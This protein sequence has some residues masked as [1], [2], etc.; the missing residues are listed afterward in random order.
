MRV[1]VSADL[2]ER[3]VREAASRRT[4]VSECVRADLREFHAIKDELMAPLEVREDGGEVRRRIIH[5]LVAEMETRVVAGLDR[6]SVEF[7]S[8]VGRQSVL[9]GSTINQAY[10]GIVV[11]LDGDI[12]AEA[13]DA[14]VERQAARYR[15]EEGRRQAHPGG[16]TRAAR[17]RRP[18]RWP[19]GSRRK[20]EELRPP[21]GSILDM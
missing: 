14:G 21:R 5:Q 4:T 3:L 8:A 9:L 13:R 7:S 12:P 17:V 16:G 11:F 19:S 18:G 15:L 10:T 6:L 1:Y 2:Y 20:P